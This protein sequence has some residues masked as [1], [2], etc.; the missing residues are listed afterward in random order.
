MVPQ[1]AGHYLA[2]FVF[3]GFCGIHEARYPLPRV[4]FSLSLPS[5]KERS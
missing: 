5:W 1:A 4:L 3:S 2:A